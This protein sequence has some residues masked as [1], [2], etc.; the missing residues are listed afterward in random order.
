M[1]LNVLQGVDRRRYKFM[2]QDEDFTKCTRKVSRK[3]NAS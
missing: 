3:I 1:I 2:R